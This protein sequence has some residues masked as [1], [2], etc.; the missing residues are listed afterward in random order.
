MRVRAGSPA[1]AIARATLPRQTSGASIESDE[2]ARIARMV[3][4]ASRRIVPGACLARSIALARMLAVRGLSSDIRVGVRTADTGG[5]EAHAWVEL[6]G[7]PLGGDGVTMRGYEPFAR[8]LSD[9]AR[10]QFR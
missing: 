9:L 7:R 2:I 5:V 6:E 4:V 10:A 1:R 8:P 3:G